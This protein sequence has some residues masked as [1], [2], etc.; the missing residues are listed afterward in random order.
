MAD[1]Q[2]FAFCGPELSAV[3]KIDLVDRGA[4]AVD[5]SG[6]GADI[7]IDGF[8]DMSSRKAFSKHDGNLIPLLAGE[9]FVGFFHST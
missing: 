6:N 7:S 8:R 1:R 2:G 9:V 4:V 5:F 3:R